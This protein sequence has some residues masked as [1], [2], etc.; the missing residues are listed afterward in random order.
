M[1][2]TVEISSTAMQTVR[3]LMPVREQE[4][5]AYVDATAAILLIATQPD[6]L[7]VQLLLCMSVDCVETI[8]TAVGSLAQ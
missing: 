7:A 4:L 8:T 6:L 2:A 5:A 1:E 3:S